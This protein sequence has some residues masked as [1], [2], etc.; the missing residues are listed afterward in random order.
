MSR[1]AVV[2]GNPLLGAG[3]ECDPT[4]GPS[5]GLGRWSIQADQFGG[6]CMYAACA[7]AP[8]SRPIGMS[9]NIGI[10]VKFDV[11]GQVAHPSDA[12]VVK[13]Q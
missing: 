7:A 4:N 1:L 2:V 6:Q 10:S 3:R 9:G 8:A 5:S 12:L 13:V 11:A